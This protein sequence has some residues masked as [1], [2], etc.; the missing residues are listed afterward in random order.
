VRSTCSFELSVVVEAASSSSEHLPP[1]SAFVSDCVGPALGAVVCLL[2]AVKLVRARDR[3]HV[4]GVEQPVARVGPRAAAE[5]APPR[6]GGG[7]SARAR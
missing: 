7:G 5:A 1:A 4:V 3:R 2:V 6:R